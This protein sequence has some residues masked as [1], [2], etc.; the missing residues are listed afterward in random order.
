M[1]LVVG[2][3]EALLTLRKQTFISPYNKGHKCIIFPILRTHLYCKYC[4]LRY[5]L[6]TDLFIACATMSKI[7]N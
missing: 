6:I 2:I 5:F 1:A 4:T 3:Y 7:L